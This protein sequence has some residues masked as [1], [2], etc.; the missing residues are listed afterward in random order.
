MSNYIEGMAIVEG[1]TEQVF[2]ELILQ[3]YLATKSIYI[4]AT[5]V[6][7]TKRESGSN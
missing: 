7:N 5:Q 3:P 1:K 6:S 4:S 2:I